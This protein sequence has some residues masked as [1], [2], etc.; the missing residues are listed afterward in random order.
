MLDLV[1]G[2]PVLGQL[3]G[4][5]FFPESHYLGGDFDLIFCASDALLEQKRIGPYFLLLRHDG[6]GFMRDYSENVGKILG[7]RNGEW[8]CSV[9]LRRN[10]QAIEDS[11]GRE[12]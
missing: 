7:T 1:Q 11:V 4:R 6:P 9:P 5:H 2:A 3:R 12:I 8:P 10:V